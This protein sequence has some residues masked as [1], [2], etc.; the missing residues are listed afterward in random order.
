MN[1]KIEFYINTFKG[2]HGKIY[3][4]D[5]LGVE[6]SLQMTIVSFKFNLNF[7]SDF[8]N[9]IA[10]LEKLSDNIDNKV[11]PEIC[12]VLKNSFVKYK[13]SPKDKF[14]L[15]YKL[16]VEFKNKKLEKGENIIEDYLK[17]V[18]YLWESDFYFISHYEK[19]ENTKFT[20]KYFNEEP[21]RKQRDIFRV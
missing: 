17:F 3:F 10:H 12:E 20:R 16:W 14:S 11:F 13:S 6:D 19:E 5:I 15:D 4:E 21:R 7:Q 8:L 9:K 2:I 18:Y 1:N